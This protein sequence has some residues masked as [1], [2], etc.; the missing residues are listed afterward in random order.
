MIYFLTIYS[1][2]ALLSLTDFIP[3]WRK[4][5]AFFCVLLLS[6]LAGWRTM[7]GSDFFIYQDI[8]YGLGLN[9]FSAE[10]GYAFLSNI[11]SLMGLS[12]NGFLFF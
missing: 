8:Y 2:V 7:G 1:L 4:A 3:K 12:F 11:F 10:A 9:Y 6:M 5:G